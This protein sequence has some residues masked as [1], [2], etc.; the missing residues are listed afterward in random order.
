MNLKP[1]QD[2]PLAIF[3]YIFTALVP[4]LYVFYGL[5]KRN[6]TLLWIALILIA[7]AALTFKYYFS[8]GHPEI[9]LTSVGIVMILVAYISIQFLKTPKYGI[10]FKEESEEDN[11][12]KTNA[13]ALLV[14]QSFSQGATEQGTQTDGFG[15]GKSGGGGAGGNY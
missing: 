14:A 12:I 7:A 9:T 3:F 15:G 2:I 4:L 1:G 10:T 13:E 8:L 11:F 6:K 5:K